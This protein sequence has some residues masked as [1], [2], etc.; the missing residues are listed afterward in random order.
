MGLSRLTPHTGL[1]DIL[2]RIRCKLRG[3]VAASCVHACHSSKCLSFRIR[4]AD[5]FDSLRR[6]CLQARGLCSSTIPSF[7]RWNTICLMRTV[8]IN[9]TRVADSPRLQLNRSHTTSLLLGHSTSRN[10]FKMSTMHTLLLALLSFPLLNVIACD[11][12]S[13]SSGCAN[14]DAALTHCHWDDQVYSSYE[15][16]LCL[17]AGELQDNVQGALD[18]LSCDGAVGGHSNTTYAIVAVVCQVYL[19]K[20]EAA[21][22]S[23]NSAPPAEWQSYYSETLY[24]EV[25]SICPENF[26]GSAPLSSSASVTLSS[27]GTVPASSSGIESSSASP[28]RTTS[29]SMAPAGGQSTSGK[30]FSLPTECT[31]RL[32]EGLFLQSLAMAL[33]LLR[34]DQAEFHSALLRWCRCLRW[35]EAGNKSIRDTSPKVEKRI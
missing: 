32:T 4:C 30:F 11:T 17:S 24:P 22:A 1:T 2:F 25:T 33:R 28:S 10:A 5:L 6:V 9:T 16:C 12:E 20:G 23:I 29:G 7:G 34:P 21:A 8:Y 31:S 14:A 27:S 18:C 15:N 13:C 26:R 19:E 3:L 35:S